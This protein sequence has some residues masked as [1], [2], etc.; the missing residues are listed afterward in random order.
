M[1]QGNLYY[2]FGINLLFENSRIIEK[3]KKYELD[4][5]TN[6]NSRTDA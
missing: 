3:L 6:R 4:R 5:R 2:V 1:V